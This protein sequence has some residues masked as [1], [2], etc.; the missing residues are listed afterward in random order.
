[1]L[2]KRELNNLKKALPDNSYFTIAEVLNIS[3]ETV[4]KVL[5]DPS[6]YRK[7]VIDEAIALSKN[8]LSHIQSQKQQLKE[9][10]A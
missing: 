5:N 9:L 10:K 4:R 6:R 8:H 1:M 2:N 3:K 7:D